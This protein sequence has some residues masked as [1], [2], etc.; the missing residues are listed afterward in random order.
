[1]RRGI[2]GEPDPIDY[3]EKQTKLEEFKRLEEPGKINL[4][5]LDETGF[6]LNCLY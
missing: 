1:M 3:K 4:Y 5:Y 2:G 6:C